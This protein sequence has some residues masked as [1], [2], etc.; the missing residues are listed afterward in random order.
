MVSAVDRQTARQTENPWKEGRKEGG[1]SEGD[2]YLTYLAE[3][4]L[5]ISL[6]LGI[7]VRRNE[8][9]GRGESWLL[10]DGKEDRRG[11]EIGEGESEGQ[12]DYE[13]LSRSFKCQRE[14][15]RGRKLQDL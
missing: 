13:P 12:G 7:A 2:K 1:T 10:S 3:L 11:R 15:T 4:Y 14:K 6:P 9:G 8:V 5:S